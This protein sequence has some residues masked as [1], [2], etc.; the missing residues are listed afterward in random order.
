[1]Y[2][3]VEIIYRAA[4]I[5]SWAGQACVVL[6]ALLLT[7]DVCS[8]TF[9][10]RPIGGTIE[11][12]GLCLIIVVSCT[13]AY[14]ASKNGHVAIEV[15]A[16]HLPARVQAILGSCLSLLGVAVVSLMAWTLYM[17]AWLE[18]SRGGSLKTTF[19]E[20]PYFPFMLV[21]S[22]GSLLLCLELLAKFLRFLVRQ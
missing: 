13:L 12:V 2:I 5:A 19:L 15:V 10:D 1:M 16:C 3:V 21:A 4:R 17:D 20:I 9:F 11:L 8:R 18:I 14:T 22:L 6:M 7:V